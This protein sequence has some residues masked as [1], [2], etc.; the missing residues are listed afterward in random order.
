MQKI[1]LYLND[2]LVDL[3]DD[4]PITLQFGIND[5]ADVKSQSGNTSNQFK[6]PLTS[7]NRRILGYPSETQFTTVLPYRKY[8]AKI[9]QDGIEVIPNG[10]AEIKQTDNST[11]DITVLS[12]N[13]DFFDLLNIKI[14]DMYKELAK[15]SQ[16]WTL[17]NVVASQ[18]KTEGLLWPVIDY[19]GF[20]GDV[21]E[22]IN[23][24]NLRPAFYLKTIVDEIV[25]TTGYKATGSMFNSALY[26]K[27]IVAFANDSFEHG[28]LF[29]EKAANTSA[30]VQKSTD[31]ISVTPSATILFTSIISDPSNSYEVAQSVY[32]AKENIKANVK[33]KYDA[34]VQKILPA[35]DPNILV[36]LQ[37]NDGSGWVDGPYN[38]HT[39][40]DFV[41]PNYFYNQPLIFDIDLQVGD[42][43]RA[44]IEIPGSFVPRGIIYAGATLTITNTAADLAYGQ[45]IDAEM[46]F[47][48]ISQKELLKDT[49][50]H[51]GIICSSNPNKKEIAFNHFDDIIKN[52]PKA[53]DWSKKVVDQ[54][55]TT[56]FQ[57][58]SYAQNNDMICKPDDNVPAKLGK[59]SIP[60]D[61][62]T[63][64]LQ[65][66]IIES[67]FAASVGSTINGFSCALIKKL[68]TTDAT[69]FTIS[70]QPRLLIDNKVDL[71]QTGK[72]FSFTD[73]GV[74][75]NVSGIVSL[76][77]FEN[78]AIEES[79]SFDY[80]RKTYYQAIQRLLHRPKKIGAF[81]ILSPID[82]AELDLMIPVYLEQESSYFYINKVSNWIKGRPTQVELVKLY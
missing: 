10:F 55:K 1:E 58:G 41:N 21:G 63:L 6:L 38:T 4:N 48:D 25:K 54:G 50:Q 73:G 56:F 36:K 9:I 16:K 69:D 57:L 8:A 26:N 59:S 2:E 61:D 19:G 42:K 35:S 45:E 78:P 62:L 67:I 18:T 81:F 11:A 65:T 23:V 43:I 24:K 75:V 14:Y 28:E 12:G 44:V 76:P 30:S 33:L 3:S 17:A 70:T 27:L 60:I 15:Y 29:K 32:T 39:M 49:F 64:P 47:P 20:T 13:V 31:Q 5:L 46:I 40:V 80:L 74:P 68:E 22:H 7:K 72:I 52:I 71:S 82:I 79:L 51:F 37:S 77:Y 66:N 34:S 53:K